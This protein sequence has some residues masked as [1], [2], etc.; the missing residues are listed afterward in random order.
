MRALGSYRPAS[1]LPPSL[2]GLASLA[3]DLRWSWRAPLRSLFEEVD[4]ASWERCAGN[5][6]AFLQSV[7]AER[8]AAF[9]ADEA[10]LARVQQ[11]LKDLEAED[12]A[13]PAD[14]VI[15][16]LALRGER[17]GYFCA[18]YGIT[19]V[20]P[21]Y[22]GGLGVLAGDHLKSASDLGA[23]LVAV[24]LF[25]REGFFRQSIAA[26]GRQ[27]EAYPI[28]D[29]E[30]L[31]IEVLR[32]PSG[33]EPLIR[34]RMARREVHLLIRKAKVGRVTLLLLDSNVPQNRAA[35]REITGRLYG[36]DLELRM[37]Q[38]ICLGIGG[39]RALERAGLHPTVFH[40]N[41]G[42]AAFLGLERIRQ[43]VQ[44]RG[45]S[46]AEARHATEAANV[47]T[48]HTPVPAGIDLFPSEMIR[49]YFED[50]AGAFGVGIEDVLRLGR[51]VPDDGYE[52]FSMAVLGLRLS[53]RVNA[54]S[55][56][57]SK[58]SRRLWAGVFPES[59]L[60]EVPIQAVTNGVHGPTWT[61]PSL[62]ELGAVGNP[63]A[64]DRSEFWRRHEVLRGDLIRGVR[65][66]LG[67]SHRQRGS[68]ETAV[69]G[70]WNTLNPRALTIGFAR[71]FATYKR[72]TL[73]FTD[74]ERLSK[75]LSRE[76]RP[77]QMIFAGK[78][79]PQDEPGK[80]FIRQIAAFAERPELKG[81]VVL[82]E[83][84]DMA[85]ARLLVRGCDVWLNNPRRP[86]EASGTSGMKAGMNGALN[87]SI[88]DGWW[89][90]AP[91]EEIGFT[92]GSDVDGRPDDEVAEELYARLEYDVIPL[93]YDRPYGDWNQV[94]A[95]WADRMVRAAHVVGKEFSTDR[96]VAEYFREAYGPAA[97]RW[98]LLSANNFDSARHLVRWRQRVEA[99]W[100]GVG[101]IDVK[102]SVDDPAL[103]APGTPFDVTAIVRLGSLSSGEIVVDWLEGRMDPEGIVEDGHTAGLTLVEEADGRA[104]YRGTVVRPDDDRRAYS[105]RLRPTHPDLIHSNEMRLVAWA[106]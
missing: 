24:G 50:K 81:K 70:A 85:L 84:Y 42:H 103:L 27:R 60:S 10:Y 97:D 21:V 100:G 32:P 62:V 57:H 51:Q 64:V 80:E 86:Y 52:S 96:M 104:T 53:C 11:A 7:D 44:E 22:S 105:V 63:D 76:D 40:A 1:T 61:H 65:A 79:H 20:L 101:F 71:R 2:G 102:L 67:E 91:R 48:T 94:P 3:L 38:E 13:P 47:F 9:A 54:V 68:R 83:N 16:R 19:E 74:F 14:P 12:G 93:F 4:P 33:D 6:V 29:A 8:L 69:A 37:Q 99:A 77:V 78:A 87:L 82:L 34:V 88:R 18:E 31:P 23:P 41:E 5:P 95:R 26:D 30:D 55:K 15:A 25:Y 17:I 43:L 73:I 92:I 56:L 35:D 36:G 98:R 45:L 39:V 46:F 66:R 58:V 28:V 59:P 72:A 89:D 90:E 49:R 106:R 75:L